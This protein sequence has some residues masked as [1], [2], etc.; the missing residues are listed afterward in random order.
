MGAYRCQ[1]LGSFFEEEVLEVVAAEFDS[2][3][4]LEFFIV[5][6]EGVFEVGA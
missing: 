3:E 6:D 1:M 4:G 5:F 2:Q